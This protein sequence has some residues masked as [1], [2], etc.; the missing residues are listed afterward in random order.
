[1]M[2]HNHNEQTMS[3]VMSTSLLWRQLISL[4]TKYLPRH[5]AYRLDPPRGKPQYAMVTVTHKADDVF[6]VELAQL[7]NQWV[8]Q[9]C[10]QQVQSG[11]DILL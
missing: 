10:E 5:A 2:I 11:D 8:S 9:S 6:V 4:S 3:M 1:M 7:E